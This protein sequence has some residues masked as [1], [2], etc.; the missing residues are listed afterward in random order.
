[1]T[2]TSPP[3][4]VFLLAYGTPESLDDVEPYFTHIRGGRKPSPEAVENLRERYRLVGGRTPLKDL[5]FATAD[6]L[7]ARLDAEAP[8]RYR[9]YVGMKHWH[10]FIAETMPHIAADGVRDVVALVLAPHYSRMSVG[11]YRRYVDEANATLEQPLQIT[12]IERWHDHPGFR[13]LIADRIVAARAELP[14][15]LHDQALVLF[16]AHSLPERILSWNDPYP[17][18]LRESAAGIA[19]LLGLTDWRLCY[20]SAG[21]TGEPWLGPDI[22]DY[23]EE[24]HSEGVRAVISAPFGFVADHLEVLWDIDRE[25]QDKAAELGMELRRI[26]MPNADDEFVDVLVSLVRDALRQRV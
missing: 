13:R 11:G 4:G 19:G 12:F 18:E 23:L 3:V 5:T 14:P 8:G 25:A 2:H 15:D 10:P 17:D 1:M 22:L 26:R 7:Q 9:V 6:K 21:M 24:L 16:S 20:Q